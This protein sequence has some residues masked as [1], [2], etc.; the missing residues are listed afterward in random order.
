MKNEKMY[1]KFVFIIAAHSIARQWLA[2][3]TAQ[4]V[5]YKKLYNTF[6]SLVSF[7][8]LCCALLCS[9]ACLLDSMMMPLLCLPWFSCWFSF[10]P[11]PCAVSF[12]VSIAHTTYG[13]PLVSLLS[14]FVTI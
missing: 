8:V 13:L 1:N 14:W 7:A 6:N 11:F 12:V 10:A 4:R 2:Y 5:N 9:L 3:S